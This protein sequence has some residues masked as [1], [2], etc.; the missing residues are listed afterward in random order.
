MQMKKI[1]YLLLSILLFLNESI[2]AEEVKFPDKIVIS[3]PPSLIEY[4][5][6]Y[7]YSSTEAQ[8]YTAIYEGLVSYDQYTQTCTCSC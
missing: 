6:L 3:F 2:S 8:L 4:N 7:T 1:V 5:P